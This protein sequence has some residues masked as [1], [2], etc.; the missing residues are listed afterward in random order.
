[1]MVVLV[2][3]MVTSMVNDDDCVYQ[4][5]PHATGRMYEHCDLAA[6]S[7]DDFMRIP[8]QSVIYYTHCA[9]IEHHLIS[10]NSMIFVRITCQFIPTKR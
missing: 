10:R 1:M 3:T 2:R 4:T 6:V 9:V 8:G 5:G 7:R